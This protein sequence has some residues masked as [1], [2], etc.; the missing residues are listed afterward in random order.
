MPQL[1]LGPFLLQ[2]RIGRG[3]MSDVWQAL[4]VYD[5]VHVAVKVLTAERA[6]KP[7]NLRMFRTEIRAV[8]RLDHP[9]VI[10]VHDAGTVPE[11]VAQLSNG[12]LQ[13]GMPY[14]VMDLLRGGSLWDYRGRLPWS[15]LKGLLS[16]LLDA[17]AHAHARG[18]IHR[19]LKLTNVL[20][21]HPERRAVI[22]DFGLAQLRRDADAVHLPAGTPSYMAPEQFR[23]RWRDFG[24]WTD[25]YGFGCLTWA[26]ATGAAPFVDDDW[27]R[28]RDGHLHGDRPPFR[29]TV[30]VPDGFEA[31]LR[32]LLER[33]LARRT[34][35]AAD[36][37]WA[38]EQLPDTVQP[39]P[40]PAARL[41]PTTHEASTLTFGTEITALLDANTSGRRDAPPPPPADWRGLR[42]R[43]RLQLRGTGL[44]L[45]AARAIPTVG[46][47]TERDLLWRQVVQLHGEAPRVR[48][49]TLEGAAGT[50]KTHLVRWLTE[51]AH[52]L[53][54]AHVLW[55]D[56]EVRGG[57]GYGVAGML[58]NHLH[59]LGLSGPELMARVAHGAHSWGT[60]DRTDQGILAEVMSDEPTLTGAAGAGIEATAA[61]SS[62]ALEVIRR[63][64]GHVAA[65]RPVIL[66][67]DDAQRGVDALL[68][69]R[70]LFRGPPLRVLV[71]NILRDQALKP[72]MGGLVA[73]VQE[74][75]ERLRVDPLPDVDQLGLVRELL[76]LEG[77]LARRVAKR[78]QGNP[79]FAV[80]LVADWIAR[81]QLVRGPGGFRLRA[82]ASDELPDDLYT[83]WA[84]DL[85]RALGD[86]PTVVRAA[87]ELGA[88][89]G[90]QVETLRW[91]RIAARAG[92]DASLD[93]VDALAAHGLVDSHRPSHSWRFAHAMVREALLRH[94]GEAGRLRDLH[95][96]VLEDLERQ[97][98][99]DPEE[100]ARH[101][102]G[103]GR[104]S[105]AIARLVQAARAFSQVGHPHGVLDL[106]DRAEQAVGTDPTL[107]ARWRRELDVGRVRAFVLLGRLD[108]ALQAA[109]RV[110]PAFDDAP[111]HPDRAWVQ[112][113]QARVWLFRGE[114][115]SAREVLREVVAR[116]RP[117]GLPPTHPER[118]ADALRVLALVCLQAQGADAAARAEELLR[119]A[120][121][122]AEAAGA[123]PIWAESS[124]F[125]ALTLTQ[126]GRN[127]EAEELLEE[128]LQSPYASARALRAGLL[129]TRAELRRSQGDLDGAAP[130]YAEAVHLLEQ[131]GSLEASVPRLNLAIL[132]A[133][134]ERY[135]DAWALAERCGHEGTV[136]GRP[137]L[138][139][140]V[141]AVLL[142]AAAG[143][144][145]AGVAAEQA[146]Q[147]LALDRQGVTSEA[148]TYE[149]AAMGAQMM[150][151]HGLEEQADAI[152]VLVHRA[153]HRSD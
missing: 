125:L 152:D 100:H 46:R 76:G 94:A 91:R 135:D 113:L 88:V 49:V 2:K 151:E 96:W 128:T 77:E 6:R 38:L 95:R 3:G 111:M 12:T 71:V 21:T 48:G 150:R 66:V 84:D 89:L 60:T 57:T 153:T 116:L 61:S 99:A 119:E 16:R 138:Q 136:Q 37:A 1:V 75:S 122:W 7:A 141:H 98:A 33:D 34:Q 115:A 147:L 142:V 103:A 45:Y 145:N 41:P 101:L 69:A 83:L 31:W 51:R 108:E 56:H 130:D 58:R 102:L 146:Q 72:G 81:D 123:G 139:L 29:P 28:V 90:M 42:P 114:T 47:Q 105:E 126:Q 133:L 54:A 65:R 19:D 127:D 9:H 39:A 73:A 67:I 14:L 132:A 143:L 124:G 55:C 87:V 121:T 52:E 44:G 30:A 10:G 110:L 131:I 86:A 59:A 118:L 17:L 107:E 137:P 82:D 106:L 78:T 149:L 40:E 8:A 79:A 68:L 97:P 120:R 53:G 5:R 26:L 64:I 117:P 35:R 148:E 25:L 11:Q 36:A 15:D 92:L 50:G 4:H 23:D 144:R 140:A 43:P 13:A 24:P 109:E 27:T 70:A 18:V 20:L 134:D 129:N 104:T 22:T 62:E 80:S 63:H 112:T 85:M 93:V 32:G 74:Q